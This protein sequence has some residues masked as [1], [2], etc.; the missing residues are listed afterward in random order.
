MAM[1]VYLKPGEA[2]PAYQSCVL[3]RRDLKGSFT[4]SGPAK[5]EPLPTYLLQANLGRDVSIAVERAGAWR[6]ASASR[7]FFVATARG[8]LTKRQSSL[9]SSG[10]A[11]PLPQPS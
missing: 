4:V 8:R 5:G 3:V 10:Q 6:T 9:G 1:V 11:Q 2:V 7:R